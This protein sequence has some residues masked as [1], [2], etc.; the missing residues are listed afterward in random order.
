MSGTV[1]TGFLIL[2]VLGVK[3]CLSG[4]RE[5]V[6]TERSKRRHHLMTEP[7]LRDSVPLDAEV[8]RD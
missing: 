1:L 5:G 4:V 6:I 3:L 8:S 7:L 2:I